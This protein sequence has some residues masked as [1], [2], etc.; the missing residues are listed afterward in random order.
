MRVSVIIITK[1]EHSRLR[2]CLAMLARQAVRW[3]ENTELIVV[4][5]GSAP[6]VGPPDI[7]TAAPPLRLL[8][9]ERAQG[10][11]AARN[12]GAE[13]ARGER[14]LFLDGDVLLSPEAATRH[15][16]LDAQQLGRGEQRHLSGTRF[17]S[18]PQTGTPWPG[19][20]ALVRRLGELSPRLITEDMLAQQP[21]EHWIA[22]SEPAI[23]PGAA[24]RK[25]YELEMNALRRGSAPM[26]EWMAAAGHNFSVD[27]RRFAEA[28]GFDREIS[29]NEHRELALRLCRDGARVVPV[30]GSISVH[31]THRE[32]WRDPLVE[33]DHW[34]RP[35]ARLHPRETQA[36]LHF[37]RSLA[38]DP[39][40]EPSTRTMTLEAVDAVLRIHGD[41]RGRRAG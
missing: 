8:R 18:D 9:H 3:N 17:F 2:L 25:L 19:K 4:D 35:F 41:G 37:W 14:L 26:A 34:E 33:S 7:P 31:M 6:A 39:Q 1:D 10:R 24:P 36:M 11:S 40:I 22:R 12:A 30:D 13:V 21:F 20:E 16:A 27:R 32:G 5:D 15:G 38:G 29:I 23:Y 28:G